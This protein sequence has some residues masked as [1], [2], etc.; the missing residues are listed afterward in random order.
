[1]SK[2][3]RK[4]LE[5]FFRVLRV[6]LRGSWSEDFDLELMHYLTRIS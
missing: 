5:S 4:V 3:L 6:F 2:S 1:M